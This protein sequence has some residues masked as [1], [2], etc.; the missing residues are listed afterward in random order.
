MLQGNASSVGRRLCRKKI[1]P[2][3]LS[4]NH[5]K[6]FL[7]HND[8]FQH[9]VYQQHSSFQPVRTYKRTI[10]A[11][12]GN[13]GWD[14]GRF[15]RTLYFFNGP[16]S[17]AKVGMISLQLFTVW[18]IQALHANLT[19][20]FSLLKFIEFV[21]GKLSNPSSSEPV[22]AMDSS[23]IVLVAGATGGVG[24]RVV[25]ILRNK[26]LPVRVLVKFLNVLLSF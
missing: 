23:G 11:Q 18:S 25:N 3:Q 12:A 24:R 5:S 10:T 7:Q 22:N 8:R 6:P 13:Q 20:F 1:H 15:F 19:R 4:S 16:P 2:G 9:L 14:L 21:V 17:P 26:G